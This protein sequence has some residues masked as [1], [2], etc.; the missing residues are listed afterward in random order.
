M[1]RGN[2]REDIVQSDQD[3]ELFIQT[4]GEACEKAGWRVHAWVL[5]SNHFHWV[6]ETPEPNLSEGM[7]WFM[8]AYTR[9]FN[10]RNKFWGH[11]FGGRYKS[12]LVDEGVYFRTL[13]DYVHLNP[14][15]AGLVKRGT[16]EDLL[17]YR[18]SSLVKGYLV[19]ASKRPKWL[20]THD[21]LAVGRGGEERVSD[22][23][24]YLNHLFKI[25]RSEGVKAGK[26]L[27]EGQG[28]QSTFSRGWY[29]GS[30]EFREKLLKIGTP[31]CYRS[32]NYSSSPQMK[33]RNRWQ[34]EE[35]IEHAL[36]YSDMDEKKMLA[37]KSGHPVK[38]AIVVAVKELTTLDQGTLAKRLNLKSAG[39]VSQIYR[40]YK[41][42]DLLLNRE[43]K[44]WLK[45]VK[46]G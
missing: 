18:W 16:A 46:I 36:K 6:L 17:H 20:V 42:G 28:G 3:R 22:R 19:P 4:L 34:A 43:M 45:N 29:W 26:S 5:M 23:R 10:T 21:R 2:R 35:L 24:Q 32:K 25:A 7:K 13:V 15:R 14:V 1:A 11:L 8:N 33:D 31:S 41:N 12:I 40:R 44:R 37:Q 38:V 27:P 39:N 9:R 30:Q